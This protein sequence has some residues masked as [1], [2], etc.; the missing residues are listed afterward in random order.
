VGVD[1]TEAGFV[2]TRVSEW[3]AVEGE[4]KETAEA[5]QRRAAPE[6]GV[7]RRIAI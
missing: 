2:A 6:S 4:A 3:G 7:N 5:T 1:V